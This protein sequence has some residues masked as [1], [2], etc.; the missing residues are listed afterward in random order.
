M[1]IAFQI[2]SKKD[3]DFF[4]NNYKGEFIELLMSVMIVFNS[5]D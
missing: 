5:V 1:I 4:M 3:L 2:E